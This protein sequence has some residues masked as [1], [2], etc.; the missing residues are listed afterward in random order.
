MEQFEKILR[1]IKSGI[2]SNADLECEDERVDDKGFFIQRT[3]F[4]NVK[5]SLLQHKVS[6]FKS[7]GRELAVFTQ[8]AWSMH[9]GRLSA[10]IKRVA[11]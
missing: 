2:E 1:H 5:E 11:K 7:K 4:S 10:L 6:D 9:G 3:V 8:Y